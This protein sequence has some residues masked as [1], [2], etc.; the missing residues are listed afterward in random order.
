[1]IFVNKN[2]IALWSLALINLSCAIFHAIFQIDLSA[3]EGFF[4]EFLLTENLV[5]TFVFSYFGLALLYAR[6][7]EKT[8]LAKM[9]ILFWAALVVFV[10][11]VRPPVTTLNLVAG[12]IF[13]PQYVYLLFLG[14]MALGLSVLVFVQGRTQTSLAT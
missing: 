13:L 14:G 4:R 1:M 10:L 11:L 12:F 2:G 6:Q 3:A 7:N 8:V 9:S 5:V